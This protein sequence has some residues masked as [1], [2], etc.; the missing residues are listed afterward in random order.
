MPCEVISDVG[1][2][3]PSAQQQ[4]VDAGGGEKNK[5]NN[6]RFLSKGGK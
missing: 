4:L 6:Q 3:S 2:A 5:K 1:D